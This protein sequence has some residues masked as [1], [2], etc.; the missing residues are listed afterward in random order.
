MPLELD[1]APLA[2]KEMELELAVHPGPAGNPSYDWARW[3]APRSRQK[4]RLS[5][6]SR[7]RARSAGRAAVD[8]RGG[9]PVQAEGDRQ[10]VRAG[11]PGTVFLLASPPAV[12]R[13]PVDLLPLP[14]SVSV[15]VDG[16]RPTDCRVA[17]VHRTTRACGGV[18]RPAFL[19][20]PPPQGTTAIH[21]PMRL[22]PNPARFAGTRRPCG[23]IEIGR[24]CVRGRGQRPP[25]RTP[26]NHSWRV[27]S[28]LRRISRR[29][30]GR[31]SC[32]R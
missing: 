31:K 5:A 16:V 30:P 27:E 15:L 20:H 28:N 13:L 10:V 9:V 25:D 8:A 23:R 6:V 2:G 26:A 4:R 24:S 21:L 11:L 29:G 17:G 32:F 12:V 1:L 3:V 7:S 22:P 19:A 14:H 18:S